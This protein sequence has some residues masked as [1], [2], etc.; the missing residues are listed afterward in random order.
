MR[1]IAALFKLN[2][3]RQHGEADLR[4]RHASKPLAVADRFRKVRALE[5]NESRFVVEQFHLRG[6]ARLKQIDDALRFGSKMR[7]GRARGFSAFNKE[8]KAKRC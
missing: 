6:T 1:R 4:G 3:E 2:F 5:L 7:A 8:A